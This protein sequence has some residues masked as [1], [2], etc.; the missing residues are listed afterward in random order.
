MLPLDV[1]AAR[2]AGRLSDAAIAKGTHPGFADLAIAAIAQHRDLFLLTRN[3]KH[4]APLGVLC[5]D[6]IASLPD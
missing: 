3:L 5:G 6:P 2:V 4:F 1:E